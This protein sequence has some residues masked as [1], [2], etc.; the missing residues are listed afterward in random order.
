MPSIVSLAYVGQATVPYINFHGVHSFRK[1]LAAT[2]RYNFVAVFW[3]EHKVHTGGS[4]TWCTRSS[5][6]SEL[7]INGALVVNNKGR[8]TDKT[9]CA[10]K[11]VPR[12]IVKVKAK[13]FSSSGTPVMHVM[14]NGA[15]TDGNTMIMRSMESRKFAPKHTPTKSNWALRVFKSDKP[16]RRIPDVSMLKIVNKA[17]EAPTIAF[18]RLSQ[19]T[20]LTAVSDSSTLKLVGEAQEVPRVALSSLS[21]LRALVP[22]TPSNDYMWIFYG[23]LLIKQGGMYSMCT[24]S[25]DGSRVIL[26]GRLLVNNDGLHGA[27]RRCASR[28]TEKGS[29]SVVVEGFRHHSGSLYQSVTYSGPD[30]GGARLYMRSAGKSAG[31]APALPPPSKWTLRMYHSPTRLN[32]M[33]NLA[34]VTFVKETQVPFIDFHSL[35]DFRKVIGA[36]QPKSNYAWAF[37]G[38]LGVKIAGTYTFCTTSDDGSQLYVDDVRVVNNDGRHS[39]REKCGKVELATGTRKMF[40]PGFKGYGS[41]YMAAHYSGPD[42]GGV[43]RYLRSDNS[44]APTKPKP[45]QWQMCMYSTTYSPLQVVLYMRICH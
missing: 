19:L 16:L 11:T 2:P 34:L 18:P 31:E 32:S 8:H 45:S 1:Y 10:K 6:G 28:Y 29:H 30:T 14:L 23:S 44:N 33:P 39:A 42:T 21:Q 5:D 36:Q 35:D 41:A 26:N 13:V 3:G 4:Y 15:D 40:V 37:Y 22:K 24:T 38:N 12:G 7:Y 9:M 27:T 17:Q 43:K 25:V 20:T